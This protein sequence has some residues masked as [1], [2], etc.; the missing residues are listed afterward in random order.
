M[1]LPETS[2][3]LLI[4][5]LKGEAS[6]RYALPKGMKYL[7][8]EVSLICTSGNTRLVKPGWY[9]VWEDYNNGEGG[10]LRV[11]ALPWENILTYTHIEGN[12]A[13]TIPEHVQTE[14]DLLPEALVMWNPEDQEK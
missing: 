13:H 7:S 8:E 12:E 1:I 4:K 14:S 10:P 5:D 6:F 2:C 11:I 9:V 3:K